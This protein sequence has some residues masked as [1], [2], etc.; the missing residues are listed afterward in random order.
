MN[1]G[2]LFLDLRWL[3]LRWLHLKQVK[4]LLVFSFLS[5]QALFKLIDNLSHPYFRILLWVWHESI[6][7]SL[8]LFISEVHQVPTVNLL[9]FSR[10]K[11][12][13]K[14]WY[15]VGRLILCK[16]LVVVVMGGLL[17]QGNWRKLRVFR[18][19]LH[20]NFESILRLIWE[21]W[22]HTFYAWLSLNLRRV[23]ISAS[24]SIREKELDSTIFDSMISI[25]A[26]SILNMPWIPMLLLFLITNLSSPY[27]SLSWIPKGEVMSEWA[28]ICCR[29]LVLQWS[30]IN[31][32]V[33]EL[34]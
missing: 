5:R 15:C 19:N 6:C 4:E 13:V 22:L 25:S 9:I 10:V 32:N 1:R 33:N 26:A 18:I 17:N 20:M 31:F 14:D 24:S 34:F 16:M 27:K 8:H 30:L 7:D 21:K 11:N 2:C 23:L 12:I 3:F 28:R 29:K